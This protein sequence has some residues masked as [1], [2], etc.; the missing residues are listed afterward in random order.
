MTQPT[1]DL[2]LNAQEVVDNPY[3]HY[4][5]IR[6][7]GRAVMNG[8]L[9][10]WMIPGH[11][12]VLSALHDPATFSSG[13]FALDESNTAM[14]GSKTMIQTDPPDQQRLRKVA[15]AAF[16]RRS[17]RTIET[18][19]GQIVEEVLDQAALADRWAAG[20]TA[21]VMDALCRPVPATV[22]ARLLGVP[23][24]DIENF[25]AWS[26]EMSNATGEG[27]EQFPDWP[28]VKAR[29]DEAG[30]AMRAYLEDQI[31]Q[32]RRSPHD[33]LIN[34]LLVA[35]EHGVLDDG[36]LIATL[37]LLLIAGNETTTKLIGTGLLL[38]DQ[39]PDQRRQLVANPDLMVGAVEEMLRFQGVVHMLPRMA[40]RNV[41]MGDSVI[42]SGEIVLLL[43]GAANR[44]PDAFP[45]PN[46]FD[47]TRTPNHHVG[48]GHGIHH[49]LGNMLARMEARMALTGFL[50]RFPEYQVKEYRYRPVFLA[51]GL[52]SLVISG[53]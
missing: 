21:D 9:G 4:E 38:L 37:V 42:R 39:H 51:R 24:A 20:E 23:D 26:E 25:V 40:T 53:V 22:I 29:A 44:D 46:R 43:R 41:E 15:Q 36:E 34:D 13:A 19:V 49:C 48:F 1:V 47:I 12:D 32:H 18:A 5:L 7:T 10:V 2:N 16:S 3:P 6:G 31:E 11:A 30:T 28:E 17:V 14:R 35:N 8:L 52:D 33:D 27:R 45:D 50:S